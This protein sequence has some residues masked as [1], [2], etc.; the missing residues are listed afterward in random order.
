[1]WIVQFFDFGNLWP[2]VGDFRVRDIALAAGIGFRYDTFFGPFRIDWGF[3]IYDPA[4]PAGRYWITQ[5]RLLGQTFKEGVFHFG[6]G[7]AF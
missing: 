3:R 5:K 1:M 4:E 2:K 7:H 6:I